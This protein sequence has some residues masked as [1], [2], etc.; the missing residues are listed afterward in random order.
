MRKSN[1]GN[2]Y[3]IISQTV[4]I[5]KQIDIICAYAIENPLDFPETKYWKELKEKA[6]LALLATMQNPIGDELQ[7]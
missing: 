6:E 5:L 4:T 3:D 7:I 2:I 1:E